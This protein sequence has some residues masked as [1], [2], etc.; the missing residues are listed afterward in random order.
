LLKITKFATIKTLFA[1]VFVTTT[2]IT[3]MI[4]SSLNARKRKIIFKRIINVRY[5]HIKI[6]NLFPKIWSLH[7]Q[8]WK[9]MYNKAYPFKTLF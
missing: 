7:R 4:R 6:K 2:F 5:P 8:I 1:L 3:E 9:G